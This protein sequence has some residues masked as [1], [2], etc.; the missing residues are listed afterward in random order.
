MRML[1]NSVRGMTPK[2]KRLLYLTVVLPVLTYGFQL[3]YRPNARRCLTMLK[4]LE[5]VQNTVA[6]WI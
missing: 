2:N 3:W 5:K 1:G 6:R 4:H